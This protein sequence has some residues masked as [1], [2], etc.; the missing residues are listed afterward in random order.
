MFA[1]VVVVSISWRSSAISSRSAGNSS[2]MFRGWLGLAKSGD[3]GCVL[4]GGV[5]L[6]RGSSWFVEL[7]VCLVDVGVLVLSTLWK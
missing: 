4:G 7:G 2:E 3:D 5:W 6:G 1:R